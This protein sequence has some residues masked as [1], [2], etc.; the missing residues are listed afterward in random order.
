[1]PVA[2]FIVNINVLGAYLAC[3]EMPDLGR[4]LTFRFQVPDSEVE[5]E[6]AAEV[7]WVNPRQQ[8]AVH[9]LPPGFGVKFTSLPD[10]MRE[11]IESF[12][13]DYAARQQR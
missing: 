12:V 9:S 10:D 11:R 6:I 4:R 8:H 5:A 2:A 1:M 7:T 13:R 3:D